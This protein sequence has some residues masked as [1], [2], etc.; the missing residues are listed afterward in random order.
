KR[1]NSPLVEPP[2]GRR[3]GIVVSNTDPTV[4]GIQPDE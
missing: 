1:R 2:P 4:R 3:E